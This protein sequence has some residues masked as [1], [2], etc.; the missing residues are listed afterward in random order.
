MRTG[1]CPT[2]GY[3]RKLRVDGM[4]QEHWIYSGLS[5]GYCNGGGKKPAPVYCTCATVPGPH[6]LGSLADCEGF[7]HHCPSCHR[8]GL[9]TAHDA[10]TGRVRP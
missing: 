2:C 1:K 4:L 8:K 10:A 5:P 7:N 6:V 9:C 3:R